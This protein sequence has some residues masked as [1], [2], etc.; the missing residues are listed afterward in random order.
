MKK[1]FYSVAVIALISILTSCGPKPAELILGEWTLDKME[2]ENLDEIAKLFF[3]E[4]MAEADAAIA[5][6]Q[7]EMDAVEGEEAEAQKIALQVQID[8]VKEQKT[9]FTIE[10]MTELLQKGLDE[11][12]GE[13][14]TFTE[15]GTLKE[16]DGDK[17]WVLSEDGKTLTITQEGEEAIVSTIVELN[18]TSLIV[19][20]EKA[21][22]E[23]VFKMKRIFKKGETTEEH[24]GE[25]T[26]DETEE[27]T[28]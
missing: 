25:E 12:K 1:L 21:K 15:D 24:D 19:T 14:S 4:T 10:S 23:K 5:D 27:E 6:L 8:A 11:M 17:K 18:A 9:S 28:H 26:E 2:A 13:V 16:A 20:F 22:D 3:D 7:T